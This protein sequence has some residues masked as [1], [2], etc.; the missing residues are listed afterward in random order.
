MADGSVTIELDAD[1]GARLKAA[2]EASGRSP[3]ELA[4]A[5]IE[6]ALAGPDA[7]WAET[8]AALAEYDRTGEYVDAKTAMAELRARLVERLGRSG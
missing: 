7:D 5:L 2:A 4:S 8:K 1:L 3:G 6:E